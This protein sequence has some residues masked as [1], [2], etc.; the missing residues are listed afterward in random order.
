MSETAPGPCAID[1]SQDE[2]QGP[3]QPQLPIDLCAVLNP[4]AVEPLKHSKTTHTAVEPGVH[5]YANHLPPGSEQAPDAAT[6]AT[7][8]SHR[9]QRVPDA[10]QSSTRAPKPSQVA[11]EKIFTTTSPTARR[12]QVVIREIIDLIES[13]SNHIHPSLESHQVQKSVSPDVLPGPERNRR[14]TLPIVI[15]DSPPEKSEPV[16]VNGVGPPASQQA[17]ASPLAKTEQVRILCVDE[18]PRP[19]L[20]SPSKKI[21]QADHSGQPQAVDGP[22]DERDRSESECGRPPCPSPWKH[23]PPVVA[24][25]GLPPAQK[26]GLAEVVPSLHQ[27]NGKDSPVAVRSLAPGMPPPS[28]VH[29]SDNPSPKLTARQLVSNS[30]EGNG[31]KRGAASPSGGS[32]DEMLQPNAS[33]PVREVKASSIEPTRASLVKEEPLKMAEK[34]ADAGT[35]GESRPLK[36][37]CTFQP[38]QS[39]MASIGHSPESSPTPSKEIRLNSIK[40]EEQKLQLHRVRNSL[41]KSEDVIFID[42]PIQTSVPIVKAEQPGLGHEHGLLQSIS[43]ARQAEERFGISVIRLQNSVPESSGQ[44]ASSKR[45]KTEP[46]VKVKKEASTCEPTLCVS[47][48]EKGEKD[49]DHIGV[50]HRSGDAKGVIKNMVNPMD[51]VEVARETCKWEPNLVVPGSHNGGMHSACKTP[52]REVIEVNG[53][54]DGIPDTAAPRIAPESLHSKPASPSTLPKPVSNCVSTE[55]ERCNQPSQLS[56]QGEH[57]TA[58]CGGPSEKEGRKHVSGPLSLTEVLACDIR[59]EKAAIVDPPMSNKPTACSKRKRPDSL[60]EFPHTLN[61]KKRAI[62][63]MS[64]LRAQATVSDALTEHKGLA[65]LTAG[66]SLQTPT[67]VICNPR[68]SNSGILPFHTQRRT[69]RVPTVLPT[70]A[71]TPAV[72]P[73]SVPSPTFSAF[74]VPRSSPTVPP[75]TAAAISSCPVVASSVSVDRPVPYVPKPSMRQNYTA[76]PVPHAPGIY[77]RAPPISALVSAASRGPIGLSG[78]ALHQQVPELSTSVPRISTESPPS[79]ATY[80]SQPISPTHNAILQLGSNQRR[81]SPLSC[82]ERLITQQNNPAAAREVHGTPS[83]QVNSTAAASIVQPARIGS[84]YLACE[85]QPAPR[86]AFPGV[87]NPRDVLH[88]GLIG[89][90]RNP[91]PQR[92]CHKCEA[93]SSS[94]WRTGPDGYQTLCNSCGLQYEYHDMVVYADSKTHRISAAPFPRARRSRVIGFRRRGCYTDEPLEMHGSWIGSRRPSRQLDKPIVIPLHYPEEQRDDATGTNSGLAIGLANGSNDK[95][96]AENLT[97]NDVQLLSPAGQRARPGVDP[98]PGSETELVLRPGPSSSSGNITCRMSSD[99]T[100][101]TEAEGSK[102]NLEKPQELQDVVPDNSEA[103]VPFSRFIRKRLKTA[104]VADRNASTTPCQSEMDEKDL[105]I[106]VDALSS[107]SRVIDV[108]AIESGTIG[109]DA[110]GV[111]GESE[112]LTSDGFERIGEGEPLKSRP[113]LEHRGDDYSTCTIAG[114][115]PRPDE[116]GSRRGAR[117]NKR[118]ALSGRNGAPSDKVGRSAGVGI[119]IPFTPV[120]E[121]QRAGLRGDRRNSQHKR[122]GTTDSGRAV[123]HGSTEAAREGSDSVFEEEEKEVGS[124]CSTNEHRN[125]KRPDAKRHLSEIRVGSQSKRSVDERADGMSSFYAVKA[126]YRREMHRLTIS[127]G[128]SFL[129]LRR[130]MEEVFQLGEKVCLTYRD[131]EDD[132]IAISTESDMRELFGVADKYSLNP[133]RVRL[134]ESFE[135]G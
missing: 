88:T 121:W 32:H 114:K 60:T 92:R 131:N 10:P 117:C 65:V 119:T 29:P 45:P 24:I 104:I 1:A 102:R 11:R 94:I 43:P 3:S 70:V 2:T 127:R 38:L 81:T 33:Q 58:D 44:H 101:R 64:N 20:T 46:T 15:D 128:A 110:I 17:E 98:L 37:G 112:I 99:P 78:Q 135:K 26:G 69:A 106:D 47:Q 120:P 123:M 100:P 52:Q 67:R 61:L 107:D 77:T 132:Y 14:E 109:I 89:R 9:P 63:T 108:D 4:T 40:K 57:R 53:D 28:R 54:V 59:S 36:Y 95:T 30:E 21:G 74:P 86:A 12:R 56:K 71:L 35:L 34:R 18:K 76:A 25:V 122:D 16:F 85:V 125:K 83:E 66:S 134:V 75:V 113:F 118:Q 8:T 87:F 13:P 62:P 68:S 126:E 48:T 129:E 84:S 55:E 7:P 96:P 133:I 103:P 124:P 97:A 111:D 39:S 41:A 115:R 50:I 42:T 72:M 27:V 73:S 93:R 23:V 80:P 6:S 22:S 91:A 116:D 130:K 49:L 90:G 82:G 5:P 51:A 79:P 19:P 105:A 31:W